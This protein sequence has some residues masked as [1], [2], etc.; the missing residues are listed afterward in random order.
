[1]E[2][3]NKAD[4][5]LTESLELEN[6]IYPFSERDAFVTIKDHKDNYQDNTKCTLI[7]PAKTDMGKVSKKI[8]ARIVMKLQELRK[9]KQWKNSYSVIDW[10]K[11]LKHKKKLTF[12]QF[13]IID[14]YPSIT[15]RVLKNALN[16]AKQYVYLK[17]IMTRCWRN[18]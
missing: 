6:R 9:F 4:K 16:F 17:M 5:L 15:E 8:L 12:L 1:M 10:F 7:N 13:D 2:N 3:V 18:V 11:S 14:F